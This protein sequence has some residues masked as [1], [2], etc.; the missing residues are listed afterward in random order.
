MTTVF[1][2]GVPDTAQVWSRLIAAIG[3]DDAVTLALPG[4]GC[5]CPSGFA[6]TKEDYLAWLISAIEAM[7]APRDLIAHDW[8]SILMMRVLCVRP[9]LVRSWVGGGAP[10]TVDYA[11]HPTARLWQ[12]PGAG[13][14]AMDRLSPELAVDMLQRAGLS[15]A[16]AR[17]TANAIDAR[18]KRCILSLYRSGQDVFRDWGADLAPLAAPGLVLWGERDLYAHPRHGDRIAAVT[19]AQSVTLDC[20]HWW[21]RERPEETASLIR[22]FRRGVGT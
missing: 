19:G 9:D 7:P 21:Q 15:A 18:M 22:A 6:A 11:W 16:D 8:G 12:T 13:E 2:H 5:A 10:F 20:G 1:I 4:F 3:D 14:K 17:E